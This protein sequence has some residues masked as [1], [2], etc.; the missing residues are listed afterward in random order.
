MTWLARRGTLPGKRPG[1]MWPDCLVPFGVW[2][3]AGIV[4]EP[5]LVSRSGELAGIRAEKTRVVTR[6]AALEPIG[7]WLVGAAAAAAAL[8]T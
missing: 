4:V 6:W 7:Q 5:R 3:R 2:C 1:C 8:G